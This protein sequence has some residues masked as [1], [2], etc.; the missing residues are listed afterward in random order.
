[1]SSESDNQRQLEITG[2]TREEPATQI[3]TLYQVYRGPGV[4]SKE[5]NKTRTARNYIKQE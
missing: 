5:L 4:L 3:K 1:M 2:Q